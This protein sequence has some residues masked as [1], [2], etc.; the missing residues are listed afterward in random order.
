MSRV[1]TWCGGLALLGVLFGCGPPAPARTAA[2]SWGRVIEVPGLGA[3][4][5]S[6]NPEV[7]SVS[8]GS[9]GN[10][11]AGGYYRDNGPQGFAVVERNGRW[12][13]AIPVPGL[14]ALNGYRDAGVLSVSCAP[15]GGC[16]A[17]GFYMED[18]HGVMGF[19]ASQENGAWG[20]AAYFPTGDYYGEVDSISCVSDGRCLAGG[21]TDD[22]YFDDPCS[23]RGFLAEE[24]NGRWGKA[25]RVPGLTVL[26]KD[27]DVSSVWCGSAGNCAAG[28]YYWDLSDHQQGFTVAEQD[29]RCGTAIGVPGLTALNKGRHAQVNSVSCA[30]AGNCVAGGYYKGSHGGLRAFAAVERNGRWGL[31]I[32]VPGLAALNKG[33]EQTQ[34]L[35]VSCA[36]AGS[37]AAGGFYYDRS[38]HRQGF[39]TTEDNG[40]WDTPIPLPGLTALNKG[41]SAQVSSLSCP[42]PGTCAAAGY[43]ADRS[44]RY[45]GFVT[46]AR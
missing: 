12:G 4:S 17:G 8:C 41:G 13:A 16:A 27:A 40:A 32:P 43:Y 38:R 31:A 46:Q 29:G 23:Q 44:G 1:V 30:S 3:L 15:A 18:P 2:V 6:G 11:A 22:C 35:T 9:A 21:E 24:R 26:G 42:S 37:C 10:C 7:S 33:G 39:V 14:A 34:V 19:A 28:G 5:T 25:A 36:P 20:N 45:H